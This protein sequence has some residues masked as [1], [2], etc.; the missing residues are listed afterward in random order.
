MENG[1]FSASPEVKAWERSQ[2]QPL[3][4]PEKFD[5]LGEGEQKL[6][7]I[8]NEEY[9]APELGMGKNDLMTEGAIKA[10]EEI[11]KSNTLL[12]SYG[13]IAVSKLAGRGA[14]PVTDN[15]VVD[16]LV[17]NIKRVEEDFKRTGDVAGFYNGVDEVRR[18]YQ[19]G[20]GAKQDSEV[21]K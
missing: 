9:E 4:Q 13:S 8:V 7:E 18:H 11:R 19:I 3:Y 1:N 20:E 21:A 6:G 2:E 16:E 10:D 14:D 15:K 5:N 12:G 17:E